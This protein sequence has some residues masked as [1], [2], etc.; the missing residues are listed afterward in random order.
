MRQDTGGVPRS[1][2]RGTP[3]L[4]AAIDPPAARIS[5]FPRTCVM[6]KFKTVTGDWVV[7]CDGRK[8]LILENIGDAK[9]PNLYTREVKEHPVPSTHEQG[10]D[11]PG[12]AFASVGGA[13]SAVD[14]TD[15]HHQL[16]EEFLRRLASELDRAVASGKPKHII[17]V[18]PPRALGVLRQAYSAPLR[19]A[20]RTEVLHDYVKLPVGEIEKRLFG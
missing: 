16:E 14:Q 5:Y 18:A 12:R 1:S 13:R 17:I 15:W 6:E 3:P 10:S 2:W 7:V 9:F 8:A 4:F 20:I 19:S 11:V